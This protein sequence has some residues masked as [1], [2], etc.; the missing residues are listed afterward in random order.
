MDGSLPFTG[1]QMNVARNILEELKAE[2]NSLDASFT[3]CIRLIEEGN[4]LNHKS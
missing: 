3:H 2:R 4:D 1:S